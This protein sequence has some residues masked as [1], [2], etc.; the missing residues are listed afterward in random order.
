MIIRTIIRAAFVVAGLIC[1]FDGM[2]NAYA[3]GL[4]RHDSTLLSSFIPSPFIRMA[5]GLVL[6]VL[7]LV[8]SG[9]LGRLA[10]PKQESQS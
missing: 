7:G 3:M 10:A 9:L 4:G 1:V 8:I 6:I 5:F 2:L